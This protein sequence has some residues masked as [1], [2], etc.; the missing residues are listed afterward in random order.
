MDLF[1]NS[2]LHNFSIPKMSSFVN[3]NLLMHG[4]V[5]PTRPPSPTVTWP[6][7]GRDRVWNA[8]GEGVGKGD[9]PKSYFET[10][11]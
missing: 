2:P 9:I 11:G 4:M 1:E 5:S 10:R 8:G 6:A 7:L 3:K